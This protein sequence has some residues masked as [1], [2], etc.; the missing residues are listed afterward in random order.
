MNYSS[1]YGYHLGYQS[2]LLLAI[3]L[4]NKDRLAPDAALGVVDHLPRTNHKGK[5]GQ[6]KGS[7]PTIFQLY[8][9][10]T[11]ILCP[12][13]CQLYIYTYLHCELYIGHHA[14]DIGHMTIDTEHHFGDFDCRPFA[15]LFIHQVVGGQWKQRP[16]A[17]RTNVFTG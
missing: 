2:W 14:L 16:L 9:H 12:F 11:P 4:W 10:C 3:G 13:S 5:F 15:H 6:Q 8:P 17:T 1:Y 7:D